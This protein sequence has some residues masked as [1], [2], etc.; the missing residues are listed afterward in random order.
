MGKQI[1]GIV[2]ILAAGIVLGCGNQSQN[3]G[4]GFGGGFGGGGEQAAFPVRAEVVVR[5]SI[6]EYITTNSTLEAKRLIDVLAKSSGRVIGLSVEEGQRVKAGQVL[7]RLDREEIELEAAEARI[8]V[9]SATTSFER[10]SELRKTNIVSEDEYEKQKSSLELSKIKLQ[11]VQLQLANTDI[12]SPISGVV[13]NRYVDLGDTINSN[14]KVFSVGDFNP[15]L[16]LIYIPERE[17]GRVRLGQSVKIT[18]ES[19]ADE[20]FSGIVRRIS[21]VVDAASGTIK[22]TIEVAPAKAK[23]RP[24]MFITVYLAVATH[25]NALVVA[26]KAIVLEREE[27]VV[28]I[29]QEDKA[30]RAPVELG[31]SDGDFVEI[32]SGLRERDMVITVGQ[33]SLQDGAG[34]RLVGAELAAAP[35]QQGQSGGASSGGVQ[36]GSDGGAAPGGGP[37]G[38]FSFADL[39]PDRRKTIEKRLMGNPQVKAEYEK[40]LKADPE[41]AKDDKKRAAFFTEMMQQFRRGQ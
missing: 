32:V 6:S 5:M 16:A 22:I 20:E 7:A 30:V 31:F 34:V 13:T 28:F 24:G 9:A 38:G 1:K 37:G 3:S 4:M 35:P 18:S 12:R 33:E 2:V 15:L 25:E 40:R 21:P 41:L 36:R 19:Y 23:L 27:E 29:M 10:A 11:K 39:P 17:M 14:Q 26:K 8:N